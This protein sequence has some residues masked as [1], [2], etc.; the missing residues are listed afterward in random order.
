VTPNLRVARLALLAIAVVSCT[1][2]PK[3]ITMTFM[4]HGEVVPLTVDDRLGIV[5]NITIP[6]GEPR[7]RGVVDVVNPDGRPD[8]LWIS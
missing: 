6:A 8:R 5:T 3:R 2:G 4:D 1:T 7:S